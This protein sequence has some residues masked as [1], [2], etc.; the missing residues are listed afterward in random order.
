MIKPL[1]HRGPDDM[2]VWADAEA[3]IA[4]G[5]RR[6]AIIDCTPTGHQP[7][8]SHD[9]RFAVVFNGEI[10]NFQRLRKELEKQG[11]PFRGHSDTE[12]LL[13]AISRWGLEEAL[14]QFNGM[15]AF[16]LWDRQER[17][18]HLVRDRLGEKPLYYGWCGSTFLFGSELK[19]LQADPAFRAE[20]NRDVLPLYLRHNCIPAPHSIY[21]DTYKLLP[22]TC[23]AVKATDP[24]NPKLTP[25]WSARSAA[26]EGC[27]HPLLGSAT[28]LL[29][30]AETLLKD[31]VALRMIAD[32]PLGAFLSGGIDSSLIVALMQAQSSTPIKTFTIGFTDR[33]YNEAAEAKAIANHLGT[34][35]TELCLT[36]RQ[37][38]DTIPELA[39]IY[40][41]PFADSSQI[42][43]LLVSRLAKKSVTVSL[44]GDG[45]D[46]IFGG[47]NRYLWAPR[48]WKSFGWLPRPA[49]ALMA[50]SLRQLSPA[51]WAALLRTAAP[52]L[53]S[54][55]RQRHPGHNIQKIGE[56]L[57]ADHPLD[58]YRRLACHWQNPAAVV[59]NARELQHLPLQSCPAG[60]NASFA[61]QM[62]LLDTLTFLPDDILVKLDRASM[63]TSLEARVPYLDHRI[64]EF[65]WRLPMALKIRDGKG[66]WLLR[67]LLAKYVPSQLTDR[68]KTGFAIP[69]GDWLRGPL[70]GWAEALLHPA[71]LSNEGFFNPAPIRQKWQ[72]H[73]SGKR[74]WEYLLWDILMFQAWLDVR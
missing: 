2:G 63:S 71:R 34:N 24:K 18:L 72:E 3:G 56:G 15:F 49:R 40:D 10:Y 7:M 29:A 14:A 20:I 1:A 27:K 25:Y 16:A 9:G 31:A 22:G 58:L 60:A 47:Y 67:Q 11:I 43:T 19:A 45:G 51:Q 33:S 8:I 6:L 57:A 73:L 38:L 66:K 13:G 50:A 37:A 70:R 36:C 42:P 65:A 30:E 61:A 35:H 41:E 69:L 21:K 62:M 55:W 28:A 23:L 4:L 26:E 39:S 64:V 68:P 12:V 5:F 54:S 53:P 52:L 17:E 46:E 74:N 44:S 48:L 59:L 32:V